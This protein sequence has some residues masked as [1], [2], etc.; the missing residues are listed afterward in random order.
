LLRESLARLFRIELG[1][2][3]RLTVQVAERAIAGIV[4]EQADG[5]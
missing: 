5:Q 1:Q 2:P 4:L 3:G